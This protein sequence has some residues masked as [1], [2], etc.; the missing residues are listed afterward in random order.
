MGAKVTTEVEING[1]KYV[2]ADS[3]QDKAVSLEGMEYVI[4]RADRAGCFAGYLK[5]RVGS[6][7]ELVN[8]RRLWYWEGASS[9]SQLAVDGVTQPDKCK[10]PT[11]V[12]H[13][14]VLNVI[15]VIPA[16]EKAR[17]SIKGVK[18]WAQ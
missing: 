11:E 2:P 6:E 5:S 12:G 14:T 16:T 1:V 18:V 17:L 4:I 9:L 7:V 8:S 15:E 13:M 10:F 3:V